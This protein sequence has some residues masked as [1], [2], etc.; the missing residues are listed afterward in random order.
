MRRIRFAQSGD[1]PQLKE[2][3]RQ[4]FPQ[5]EQ[6]FWDWI[7]LRVYS[8]ENTLVMVENGRITASLQMIPC[9]MRLKEQ[10][11]DAHYIYA[12]S[13]LPEEQGRGLMA[14]LL[15]Q[16]A[17]EG[18]RRG[19]RFS[20]LIT[21]EDSLLDYYARFGYE[22][23]FMVSD[24]PPQSARLSG[25]HTCRLAKS[26]DIPALSQIYRSGTDGLLCAERDTVFWL[27]QLELFGTGAKVLERD[28]RI[29]AYAFMDE[30]GIIEAAGEDAPLL[31][32]CLTPGCR[33]RTFPGKDAHPM[34]SIRP[35]DDDACKMMEQNPCYL[36]LMYN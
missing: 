34:G 16:A 2:L 31:A 23:R 14:H 36:N 20:V 17:E 19:N 35:L 18:R 1:G 9:K 30:R 10:L 22:S 15:A 5:D 13:T 21:Q 11:F 29:T 28:G 6:S 24:V 25:N 12:A 32:S 26:A 7:F 33:W 4:C 3:Y 8:P 27:Q